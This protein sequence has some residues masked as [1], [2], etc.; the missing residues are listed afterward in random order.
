MNP[1]PDAT[2]ILAGHGSTKNADSKKPVFAHAEA[3]RQRG[4]FGEV[5]EAFWKERPYF[6]EALAQMQSDLIYIV[7]LFISRGYFTET[8][9]PREFGLTGPR[10]EKENTLI[11]YCE[12]VGTHPFMTQV[13]LHRARTVALPHPPDPKTTA[14]FIVGHGT[15]LNENSSAIVHE[16]A[17]I[18]HSM[19][20]YAECHAAFMEEEPFIE[21]WPAQTNQPNVI[22]VPFFISD[23]L[24]S[25]EGIPALLGIASQAHAHGFSNP[26][27][28]RERTIWYARAIGTEP[29]IVDLILAQ[30]DR[31]D[32][33]H[34]PLE[35]SM[36]TMH[37][38][39]LKI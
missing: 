19:G 39:S 1:K 23:G 12:P 3:I 37:A 15:N 5:R 32:A 6:R 31:F 28:L 27:T 11:N 14:L 20:I 35:R 26:T 9:L 4:L 22:V 25:H 17:R 2:L 7:P 8:V 16:Q 21:K 33:M 29:K 10:T 24:H 30:I 38:D 34:G 36:H 13:L 18:I